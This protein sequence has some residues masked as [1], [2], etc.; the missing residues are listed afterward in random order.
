MEEDQSRPKTESCLSRARRK[1]TPKASQE[2]PT[3]NPRFLNEVKYNSDSHPIESPKTSVILDT[4]P[5]ATP[6]AYGKLLSSPIT[7]FPTPNKSTSTSE[8]RED[9]HQTRG[10][11]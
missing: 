10:D 1:E 7:P 8:T 6:L 9:I 5:A 4:D 2:S 3:A 11:R